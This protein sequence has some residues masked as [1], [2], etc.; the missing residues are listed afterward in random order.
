MNENTGFTSEQILKAS[1]A[2]KKIK[3]G[4][5]ELL[6]LYEK[7]FSAQE[8]SKKDIIIKDYTITPDTLALKMKEKF[9][10]ADPAEFNIDAE[11]SVKLFRRICEILSGA[12]PEL[13]ELFNN[14]IKASEDN[15]FDM[16]ALFCALLD[17]K[18]GVYQKIAEELKI[19]ITIIDFLIYNSVKP[20]L[21]MFAEK[22]SS[23]LDKEDKWGKGYCPVC[24]SPAVLSSLENEGKRYLHCSFCWHKWA[25]DRIYCPFCENKDQE[26]LHYYEFEN[27]EEHRADVCDKCKKYIKTVDTRKLSRLMYPPLEHIATSHIDIKIKETGYKSGIESE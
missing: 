14:I 16:Q 15:K 6:D 20:S 21:Q 5:T 2:I 1:A 8:D 19:E 4:Y 27:E 18:T 7:I 23:Y 9:P 22:I 3:T 10:L 12:N 25:S 26:T 24:G 11:A 17:D 13:A